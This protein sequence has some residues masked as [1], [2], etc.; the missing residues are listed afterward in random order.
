M[1]PAG[2]MTI[3]LTDELEQ[4]VRSEVNEGAFASNSEYIRE[5]VRERYRKKMARDEKLKALDA[6]LARG[7]ADADAG[8]GLPLKEAFQHIRATLGLP[9]D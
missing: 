9:S 1:K 4:F 5:L 7:I 6:A 3:T 2:Q 8:R